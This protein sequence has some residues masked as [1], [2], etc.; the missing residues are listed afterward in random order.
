MDPALL[1]LLDE[2]PEGEAEVLVRLRPGAPPPPGLRVTARLGDVVAGRLRRRDIVSVHASERVLSLK[3]SRP[4]ALPEPVRVDA[5]APPPRWA[6]RARGPTG[7]GAVVGV[8]DWGVDFAH[9]DF[10]RP[11]GGTRLLALWD[12]RGPAA[13]GERYGR[14]VVHRRRELDRALAAAD[15]YEALGYHPADA[16]PGDG[17]HGTHTLGIAAGNGRSGAPPGMAPGADLI[18]VHLAASGIDG[19]RTLGDSV[20]LFEA[21][22]FVFREAAGRPCAINVSVG[23]HGGPHDGTT[24][25]EQG[26]DAALLD[27]PGR[28]ISQSAGNYFDRRAHVSGSVEPFGARELWLEVPRARQGEVEVELWYPGCDRLELA[29]AA[30]DGSL[31]A[32]ARLGARAE[33]RAGGRTVGRLYHR[34]DD[35]NNGDHHVD[36]FLD[37]GAPGGEWLILVRAREIE[38]GRF[39][40]WVE[41]ASGPRA[42]A[43]FVR[44]QADP[45]ATTGT[46]C[47]GHRT[48]AVGAYD[49]RTPERF[50]APFSSSG[51]TR[52]G[53]LKPDLLAPGVAITSARST[54][55]EGPARSRLTT[56][57]GT[58]MAAPYVAGTVACMF[59]AAGRSLEIE[60]TRAALF[61]ACEAAP[62]RARFRSG[63]GYLSPERAIALARALG[64]GRARARRVS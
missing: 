14:G 54:P 31:A 4:I 34:E 64:A 52:D 36:L 13:G 63:R 43:T 48:V 22:D 50:V 38:D 49:A 12:Q 8:I 17:S 62:A 53:R 27:A 15:P 11:D 32:R 30:P 16:D 37:A 58:S 33:V 7:A 24:L 46:I 29:I 44:E 42:Q 59:E 20:A 9:P 60:E 40:A 1:E 39:H 45:T 57:S 35:P 47:N 23:T 2:G 25:L 3:A 6:P 56:M 5:L 10:R 21:V 51:P 19:L 55:R 41:R 18:F 61:A 28:F 26:L